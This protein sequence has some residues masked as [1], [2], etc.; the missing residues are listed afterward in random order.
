[1][2]AVAL[3]PDENMVAFGTNKAIVVGLVP[4]ADVLWQV[5][6]PA[7]VADVRF[8]GERNDK[9][10][11]AGC[12]DWTLMVLNP[13]T[14]EAHY[15]FR[16]PGN[17]REKPFEQGTLLSARGP[18]WAIVAFAPRKRS[19]LLA[20]ALAG[21]VAKWGKVCRLEWRR[22]VLGACGHP[23][24]PL[25]LI[26]HEDGSIRAYKLP[27]RRS[28]S[29]VLEPQAVVYCPT[30]PQSKTL[31]PAISL[32]FHTGMELVLA[33]DKA[34]R[35][36][37]WRITIVKGRNDG[38]QQA[39]RNHGRQI[40]LLLAWESAIAAKSVEIRDLREAARGSLLV[41]AGGTLLSPMRVVPQ[42]ALEPI[43]S[44]R[45]LDGVR[46]CA[47]G[48]TGVHV[49]AVAQRGEG[50]IVWWRGKGDGTASLAPPCCEPLEVVVS[51]GRAT[52]Q[53]SRRAFRCDLGRVVTSDVAMDTAE[54]SEE[55]EEPDAFEVDATGKHALALWKSGGASP[56]MRTRTAAFVRVGNE[57]DCFSAAFASKQDGHI[58]C[59]EYSGLLTLRKA[60]KPGTE[61]AHFASHLT[62]RASLFRGPFEG[63]VSAFEPGGELAVIWLER[64]LSSRPSFS[65]HVKEHEQP[66]ACLRLL[67]GN[68]API[69][70]RWQRLPHSVAAA[71]VLTEGRLFLVLLKGREEFRVL[72]QAKG[73]T[74]FVWFGPCLLFTNE[75][76]EVEQLCWNGDSV[77][78]RPIPEPRAILQRCMA[79]RLVF[80]QQRGAPPNE[81][82]A[83]QKKSCLQRQFCPVGCLFAGF[84]SL[85]SSTNCLSKDD[86]SNAM[87]AALGKLGTTAITDAYFNIASKCGFDEMVGIARANR[88]RA[89]PDALTLMASDPALPQEASVHLPN[90]TVATAEEALGMDTTST[91]QFQDRQRETI[92][93]QPAEMSPSE[94]G[95]EASPRQDN[96]NQAS[97]QGSSPQGERMGREYASSSEEEEEGEEDSPFSSQPDG[98]EGQSVVNRSRYVSALNNLTI[99]AASHSNQR[100]AVPRLGT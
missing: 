73:A 2:R 58:A 38:G 96:E 81:G 46:S 67:S 95:S 69:R 57:L 28:S 8:E 47:G 43:V 23:T 94:A 4:T 86:A 88:S 93:N 59:L 11:I 34:G 41:N 83:E 82:L 65:Q 51:G 24:H 21:G 48:S 90:L 45:G 39:G 22:K 42:G 36:H 3:H 56:L 15:A 74:S 61:L 92:R 44:G 79:D 31:C 33:G 98:P 62:E 68:E 6:A 14:G 78:A 60:A 9:R 26:S 77:R 13:V 72:A 75:A 53:H 30:L 89:Q 37:A 29:A 70:V 25:T 18:R 17:A 80:L 35:V 1:M 85:Q 54:E 16:S 55:L 99:G 40:F 27:E 84:A 63:T 10:I 50:K 12:L 64:A 97:V 100:T 5:Q 87:K 52:V 66:S 91:S 71:G 20:L 32:C 49:A 19:T 76:G 7:P